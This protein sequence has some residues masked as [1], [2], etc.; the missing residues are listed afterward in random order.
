MTIPVPDAVVTVPAYFNF[1]Q[2]RATRDAAEI[3]GIKVHRLV[4]E[5]TAACLSAGLSRRVQGKMLIVD[6]GA[7]TLDVSYLDASL[8]K[9]GGVYQRRAGVR[10]HPVWQHDM[11]SAIEQAL[12]RSVE[13]RRLAGPPEFIQRRLR[14]AAEQMKIALSTS[15]NA[16]YDLVSFAGRDRVVLEL[17][18]IQLEDLLKP[19]LERLEAVCRRA[20]GLPFDHLVLV[21]GPMFSPIIR[22]RIERLVGRKADAVVDPRTAVAMGAACQGA[23]LSNHGQVPFLLLRRHPSHW[24]SSRTRAPAVSRPAYPHPRGT[25]IPHQN[26][27]LY[28]TTEDNQPAVDVHVFQGIGDSTEPA[29]NKRLGLFRLDGLLPTKAGETKID[30]SFENRREWPAGGHRPTREDRKEAIIAVRRYASWL[31]P[32]ERNDMTERM[33]KGQRWAGER[34]ELSASA[35]QLRALLEKLQALEVEDAAKTWHRHFESFQ[36]SQKSPSFGHL[37]A[38][39]QALLAEMY[40][41]GQVSCDQFL[42]ELDRVR[43]LPARC[44]RFLDAEREVNL[45]AAESGPRTHLRKLRELGRQ[46]EGQRL[47]E[48]LNKLEPL[49]VRFQ[50]WRAA[51]VHCGTL[52]ADPRDR[53]VACT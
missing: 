34:A 30:I 2:R 33:T 1:D 51:L 52:H 35:R 43:N 21:G 28:V 50:H 17:S 53:M 46:L 11:D 38:A 39:D 10:R 27:R 49:S 37:D 15:Q 7:G 19:H 6:L 29:A 26:R 42:L 16:T 12:D 36:R 3:A 8:D 23:M 14:A 48:A 25:S 5:P 9:G 47:Y 18:A 13:E 44:Q 24:A 22:A 31:S 40:N 4:A 20:V 45:L 32:S 41:G